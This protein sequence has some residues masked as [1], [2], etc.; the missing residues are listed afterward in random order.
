MTGALPPLPNTPS[1]R[2]AQLKHR[3]N[4][5]F[6]FYHAMEACWESG[7]IA[8]PILDLITRWKVSGHLH[9]PAALLPGKDPMIPIGQEA[10]WASVPF[11]TWW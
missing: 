1:W 9:A 3:D 5:I 10:G 11:S 2:G 6:T 7:G 8:P 4:F